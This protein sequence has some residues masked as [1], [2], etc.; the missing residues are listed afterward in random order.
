MKDVN[1]EKSLH[2]LRH[3]CAS[4]RLSSGQSP[5]AVAAHLGHDT[6]VL[7]KIYS[8]VMPGDRERGV[9]IWQKAMS[10]IVE[11]KPEPPQPLVITPKKP[12]NSENV[13]TD[14]ITRHLQ[15]VRRSNKS[16]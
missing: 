1:I 16:A 14:V 10:E 11:Q 13:I 2:K 5:V 8:H 4:V 9:S 12:G 7:L 3:F 15:I 6:N